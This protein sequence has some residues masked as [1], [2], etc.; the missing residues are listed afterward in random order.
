MTPD[1]ELE[2]LDA[3]LERLQCEHP[4]M[5]GVL[6]MTDTCLRACSKWKWEQHGWTPGDGEVCG[7]MNGNDK[8]RREALLSVL[9]GHMIRRVEFVPGLDVLKVVPDPSASDP[10]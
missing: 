10:V 7:I 6:Q 8:E 4:N 5:P 3:Q 2:Q 9:K 1:E